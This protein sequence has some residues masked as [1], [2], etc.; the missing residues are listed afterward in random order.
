MTCW[1]KAK[2]GQGVGAQIDCPPAENLG[3]LQQCPQAG[4][5]VVGRSEGT[6]GLTLEKILIVS[7]HGVRTPFPLSGGTNNF[8]K[9]ERAWSDTGAS[10][11]PEKAWGAP[12]IGYLTEHAVASLNS[13]GAYL[14]NRLVQDSAF[15]PPD[16]ASAQALMTLYADNDNSTQRDYHTTVAL[17]QGL[18]PGCNFTINYD[19]EYVLPLFNIGGSP[20]PDPSC[21]L[22]SK[23]HYLASVG[24]DMQSVSEDHA[25]LI[26]QL[27]DAVGCCKPALCGGLTPCTLM[28][29]TTEYTKLWFN[30][31]NGPIFVGAAVAEY[32]QMMYLNGM[33]WNEVAQHTS[34]Q[35]LLSQI[36]RLHTWGMDFIWNPEASRSY[37]ASL[38]VHIAATAMQLMQDKEIKNLRSSPDDKLVFYAAHDT[39]LLVLRRVLQLDYKLRSFNEDQY[40]PAQF[41]VFELLSARGVV[42]V[43]VYEEAMT[44]AQQRAGTLHGFVDPPSRVFVVIPGCSDGPE[45]SCPLTRFSEIV[46]AGINEKCSA[47]VDPDDLRP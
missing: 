3:G 38:G 46:L 28:N 2:D 18:Y 45:D 21:N 24:G 17:M 26:M 43:K 9:D 42:Y 15:L 4:I 37:G 23:E 36:V 32:L 33:P 44:N 5:Q 27:S 13:F 47:V 30:P 25:G 10:P 35:E 14:R 12:G 16:C 19:A 8:S 1:A 7:R 20:V 22:P 29:I 41:L 34:E 39:N 31:W 11:F 6:Q 40:V